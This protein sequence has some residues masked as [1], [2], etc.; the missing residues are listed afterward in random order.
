MST[1]RLCATVTA[2]TTG[3]LRARRDAVQGADLVELRLDGVRD[4]S[5]A[6]ALAGRRGPVIVTCRPAWEGGRFD[7]SEEERL[8]LLADAWTLGAEYVDIE[9][10]AEARPLLELSGGQRLVLSMHDYDGVPSDLEARVLAMRST[11]AEVL[12]VA[13]HARR[14]TDQLRLLPLARHGGVP[15][16]LVA[17]GEAGLASRLLPGRFGSCWTYAGQAAPGQMSLARM[18]DEFSVRAVGPRTA[19]YGVVGRPV[20]HS[21]SPAMHNAAFRAAHIDA[22][23]LP[24]ASETLEDFFTFAEALGVTG[25]SVTAPFKRDAFD[26][27]DEADPLSRRIESVNTLRR[28]GRGWIGSNTDIHGFLAPL[29]SRLP[30]AGARAAILGAGGAARS[31]AV[32]LS[33]AGAL[34]RVH[35]RRPGQADAVA[36]LCGGDTGAWPPAPGDW[37]LLV[38]TTPVGTYPGVDESPLPAA[39]VLGGFVYDLV[40]NPA[41]TRLLRDAAR[42]GCEVLGGLEMLIAQAQQQF[43]WWTGVRPSGTVMRAA[44][45]ARL[46]E[47]ETEDGLPAHEAHNV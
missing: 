25:A 5:A 9:W 24:L 34:V 47:M 42:S 40:Y 10:K 6:G 18:L 4:A 44:A 3:E 1:P 46:H 12:K 36:A 7:G 39:L 19:L 32:G 35:A 22:V 28:A 45:E 27:V 8:A 30:L 23:Y 15:I 33:S 20:G 31:V 43:E 37:D 16:A 13:V 26:A 11:G 29:A 41:S 2:A 21:L 38:N 14:L 17:M